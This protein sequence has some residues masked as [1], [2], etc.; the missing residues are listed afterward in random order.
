MTSK[1]LTPWSEYD[2]ATQEILDRSTVTLEIFDGD[3]SSLKLESLSKVA[4]LRALLD[5]HRSPGRLTIVVRKA[6]FV[7]QYSPRLLNLLS[8]YAPALTISES[9]PHLGTLAES[10]LIADG[11][12]ALVRFHRD[13]P[14]SRLIVD[15]QSE[16]AP[17]VQRFNEIVAA[18]VQPLSPTTLGL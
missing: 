16:C 18:G 12:H 11:R 4:A 10:L 13:Q 9:P 14:R 8:T 3:L 15:D 2:A 7:R 6:D 5:S 1:L 17:V